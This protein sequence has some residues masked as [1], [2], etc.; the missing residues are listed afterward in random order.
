MKIAITGGTGFVGRNLAGHLVGEG[1]DVVL[2]AR[3]HDDRDP[4]VRLLR[5]VTL[6]HASVTDERRLRDAFSGCDAVVH[7]AGIANEEAGQSFDSVHVRGTT[8]TIA[9]ARHQGVSR[10]VMLSPVRAA[11]EMAYPFHASKW[12]AEE[13]VRRSGLSHTVVRSGVIF[14]RGD[15][16]LTHLSY[17]LHHFPFFPLVGYRRTTV[18]PVA[19]A[20]VTAVLAAATTCDRLES[21]TVTTVGPGPLCL[22]D[23]VRLVAVAVERHPFFVRLPAVLRRHRPTALEHVMKLPP[24]SRH[25]DPPGPD[26]FATADLPVDLAPATKFDVESIRSGLP[27]PG[28]YSLDDVRCYTAA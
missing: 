23:V 19:I 7:L 9:A 20:D 13:M 2:I 10:V 4:R 16:L 21:Q 12:A 14:G 6:V 15:Q 24:R 22:S 28:P 5:R 3:G 25:E 26:P 18:R 27:D 8:S 17:A 1:H 11:P